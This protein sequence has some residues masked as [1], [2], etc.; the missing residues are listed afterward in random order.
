MVQKKFDQALKNHVEAL[1]L[2]EKNNWNGMK[3]SVMIAIGQ[4]YADQSN[5]PEALKYFNKFFQSPINPTGKIIHLTNTKFPIC[6][7]GEFKSRH[8]IL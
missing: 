4:D 2:A 1:S 5:Y 6:F 8:R 3:T 7:F